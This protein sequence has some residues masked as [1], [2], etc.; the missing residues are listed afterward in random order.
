M[1]WEFPLISLIKKI[2]T[3]LSAAPIYFW[4]VVKTPLNLVWESNCQKVE[5]SWFYQFP[6]H[7]LMHLSQRLMH[8]SH[9]KVFETKQS[10]LHSSLTVPL[11]PY[12]WWGIQLINLLEVSVRLFKTRQGKNW[13]LVIW[14]GVEELWGWLEDVLEVG[15]LEWRRPQPTFWPDTC[16]AAYSQQALKHHS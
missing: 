3:F 11:G 14:E 15:L 10:L 1:Q 16:I 2:K 5:Q 6:T 13:K 7:T 12:G 4:S 9:N 8:P